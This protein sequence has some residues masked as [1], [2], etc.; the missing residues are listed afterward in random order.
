LG[1]A[2]EG[3]DLNFLNEMTQM[4]IRELE[5]TGS[6]I[7]YMTGNHD[8]DYY[9]YYKHELR[10]IELPF[11]DAV[12][13]RNLWKT[14]EKIEDFY[15][16][17]EFERFAFFYLTDHAAHD[18]SWFTTHGGIHGDKSRYPHDNQSYIDLKNKIASIKKPV[19]T[20]SH[21]AFSG[22]NRPADLLDRMLPLPDN[23]VAHFYGHAHIGD[24][25]CVGKDCYRKISTVDNQR[26]PQIDV[27]SLENHRGNAVRSVFL[28][29]YKDGGYGILFRNHTEKKWDEIYLIN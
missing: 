17:E 12:K 1:D 7:C 18:G 15:F 13:K 5:S 21:Y 4:Q 25:R 16:Y 9:D 10:E 6:Q 26:I 29:F 14:S 20:F 8:F 2:V 28:E 23:L 11:Y 27:A 22:G 19:F 24:R 3:I